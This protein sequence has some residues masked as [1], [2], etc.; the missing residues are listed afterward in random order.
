MNITGFDDLVPLTLLLTDA[1][2]VAA[3]DQAAATKDLFSV[4]V[5]IRVA[6][7]GGQASHLD[8]AEALEFGPNLIGGPAD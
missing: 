6:D 4:T 8:V 3:T 5:V 1:G 2:V 7:G